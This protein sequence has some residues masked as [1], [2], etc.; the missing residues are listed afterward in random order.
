MLDVVCAGT[1]DAGKDVQIRKEIVWSHELQGSVI[2]PVMR[3]FSMHEELVGGRG[4]ADTGKNNRLLGT[5]LCHFAKT[6]H[7]IHGVVKIVIPTKKG[8]CANRYFV[9]CVREAMKMGFERS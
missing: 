7:D 4:K 5:N 9:M 6:M 1:N 8:S 2:H 3:I